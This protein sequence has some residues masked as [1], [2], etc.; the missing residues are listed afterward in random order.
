MSLLGESSLNTT[1]TF[2]LVGKI[3]P[4]TTKQTFYQALRKLKREEVVVVRGRNISLSH[5]WIQKMSEFFDEAKRNYSGITGIG[6]DFLLLD[7][8]EKVSYAFKNPHTTDIFWG[9]AIAILEKH[10]KHGVPV[11]IYN[12]HEWFL[13]VRRRSE[14]KL[15]EQIVNSEKKLLILVGSRDP[16]DIHI[17]KTIHN[18]QIQYYASADVDFGKRN[19]YVNIL[20]DYI[21]EAWLDQNAS[22]AID[23][24][25]KNN[26]NLNDVRGETLSDI[27]SRKGKNKLSISRNAKRAEKLRNIFKKSFAF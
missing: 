8:G 17:G 9:H 10:M 27:V 21:I 25:Y 18:P 16:L 2:G 5:I 13:I 7:E 15:F 11:C 12:P 6:E 1:K 14:E 26:N 3:R 22:R 20:G 23:M 4:G 24:F 19:Y